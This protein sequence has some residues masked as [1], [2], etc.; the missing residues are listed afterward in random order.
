MNAQL[1]IDAVVRQ[2]TVLIA[3][4]ATAGGIRAPLSH[5]A[6]Q[7]LVDLARELSAQGISRKV[8]A[9]MFG[10]ALRAYLRKI[11]RLSESSTERGRSLWE[12]VLEFIESRPLTSRAEVLGQFHRDDATTVL[13]ILRDLADTG[14]VFSSG[15]GDSMVFKALNREETHRVR[16][17]DPA[18]AD[19]LLAVLIYREGPLSREQLRERAGMTEQQLEGSLGRL[20]ASRQIEFDAAGCLRGVKF[21]IPLGDS[22]GWEAA[23]LDHYQALVQTLC[24]R[25]QTRDP[26]THQTAGGAT[27]TFEVWPGHPQQQDVLATLAR[28]R[29][30]LSELRQRVEAYNSRSSWPDEHQRVVCYLGQ[31]ATLESR[32]DESSSGDPDGLDHHAIVEG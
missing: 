17:Q 7:V 18:C 26:S 32:I 24:A 8:S 2:T 28:F 6:N 22:K 11:R 29:R 16:S 14:L 9:D 20:L 5:I 3:Q 30:E 10:M 25:L 1:L 19:A 15:S 4:L 27:Y 23:L 31:N 12:A 21:H 13:G